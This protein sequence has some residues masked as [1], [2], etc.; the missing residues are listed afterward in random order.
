MSPSEPKNWTCPHCDR[1]QTL[2]D[3]QQRTHDFCLW[4]NNNKFGNLGFYI[5]LT[6]CA[7]PL[8]RDVTLLA[9]LTTGTGTFGDFKS[10][11]IVE[12]FML[13]PQGAAKPQPDYIPEALRADYREAC[14]IRS[15]SP[16]A[17]ATLAR[18]CLQ[19]MI[20]DFCGIAKN[21]LIDEIQE[22]RDQ[23]D[24]HTAA[25]GVTH[26]SVDAIDAVRS[27]GN[28]GAHMEKDVDLIVEI[29]PGEAQMLI[30][31]IEMLFAEWYVER[32]SR[33][34]R[35]AE[36]T[37]LSAKKASELEEAKLTKLGPGPTA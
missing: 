17:S 25:K 32:D 5:N 16:K 37:A 8:C 13:K 30:D 31:L 24:K 35:L 33:T 22:L 15:L 28:I 29:D 9:H 18:R 6:A 19:G 36:I 2:T 1:P 21:R 7:N 12:T 34:R 20:R 26:E 27:V 3:G 10:D 23:L 4:Q 14:S 11:R